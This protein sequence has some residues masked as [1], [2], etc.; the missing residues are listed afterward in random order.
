MLLEK[1]T[2]SKDKDGN[3]EKLYI[4]KTD[5]TH[6][7]NAEQSL[8][9]TERKFRFISENISDFISIHDPDWHFTYASPSIRNILGYEPEEILG[10]GGFDLVHPDD[11]RR[12]LDDALQPIVLERKETQLRYRMKAKNGEYKWVE[13]YS[14]PVIDY[15]GETSSI[16]S[17][18]RDVTDQVNAENLLKS[19][20]IEREQ[21]LV[22]LEQSLAKERELNELRSMFVSTASHQFRTPLTVIQ[23][24][25]EI[26]EMYLEDL[27][28]EKQQRFQRQ[29]DKI[30]GEV[31]RL[32][33]LMSDILLLGR[34]N[35]AR[36]PFQPQTGDL[37]EF[38]KQIIEEK[39]NNRYPEDRK[40][41]FSV[42][43]N[44][45][46][47]DFDPKLI[48]HA[49]E[50]IIS[51]AYKYSEEGNLG[52]DLFFTD[53]EVKIA[54]S[55]PGIGIPEEELKNLFQPF[56]RATNTNEIE[57]T[58]LGLAIMKEFVD[59]HSGKIFVTSILNK[60]TTVNV[61]LPIKQN[62]PII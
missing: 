53:T 7:E 14:K 24:G 50:N 29:F 39:Y 48:G 12:T 30:Q 4:V 21:L 49:I 33:Y 27:P 11:V 16:I 2:V 61:I 51:N 56:Y 31:E 41:Y 40:I 37:I 32:Q 46:P 18:T 9:E 25:V 15:K 59:K 5:Y 35:A 43:G 54:I 6:I 57:G 62:H 45:Q 8:I 10:L 60:G 55:D 34:A 58:G 36:T 26:M 13:T 44:L 17:S 3:P 22:E 52:F 1:I 19:S 23:S 42:S 28:G 20:V 47:V 38:C